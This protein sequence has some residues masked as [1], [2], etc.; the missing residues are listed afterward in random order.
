MKSCP[1]IFH[2]LASPNIVRVTKSR[3]LGWAGH[4]ARMEESRSA[5]KILTG[6]ATGK[7]PVQAS[8]QMDWLWTDQVRTSLLYD[9][10]HTFRLTIIVIYSHAA[11]LLQEPFNSDNR[12]HL[13]LIE[14]FSLNS[15]RMAYIKTVSINFILSTE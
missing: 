5:F 8:Y 13:L 6:K 15:N 11:D 4:V 14:F 10:I 3:R 2:T 1:R 7:R 9:L 12:R